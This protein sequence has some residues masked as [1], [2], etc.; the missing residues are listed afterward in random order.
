MADSPAPTS[1][2]SRRLQTGHQSV[3]CASR[4][5]ET[6]TPFVD[7]DAV[8]KKVQLEQLASVSCSGI[9]C[10]IVFTLFCKLMSVV[11][12]TQSCDSGVYVGQPAYVGRVTA[13]YVGELGLM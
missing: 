12:Q 6:L 1:R 13:T 3:V 7:L 11:H 2:S 10:V 8:S 5:T 9:T 4:V